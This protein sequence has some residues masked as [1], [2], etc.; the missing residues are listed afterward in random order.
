MAATP[1]PFS[2]TGNLQLAADQS[3]PQD[4][5]PFNVSSQFTS[6]QESVLNLTTPG[7]QAIPF[8][9]VG[10]PG[11]KGLLIRYDAPQAGAQPVL[12]TLNS[13]SAPTEISPGGMLLIFNPNPASGIISASIVFTAACVLRVWVLG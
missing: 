7:T 2:F 8:G 11:A 5:I 1:Q 6:L 13:G 9:T 3:L 4:P 10:A 12:V